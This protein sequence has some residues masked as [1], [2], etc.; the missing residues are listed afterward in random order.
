MYSS[1][2]AM[3][4][5]PEEFVGHVD[6]LQRSL[7]FTHVRL[8]KGPIRVTGRKGSTSAVA[9]GSLLSQFVGKPQLYQ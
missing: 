1:A 2:T 3:S 7:P 6:R 8:E 9:G 5:V 4:H